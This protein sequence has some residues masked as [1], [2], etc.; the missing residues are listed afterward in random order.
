M[1]NRNSSHPSANSKQR[2]IV[3][4]KWLSLLPF[5][6]LQPL[7]LCLLRSSIIER[8]VGNRKF[9]LVVNTNYTNFTVWFPSP[10]APFLLWFN[11]RAFPNFLRWKEPGLQEDGCRVLLPPDTS[12]SP[13]PLYSTRKTEKLCMFTNKISHCCLFF[14][15]WLLFSF[16]DSSFSNSPLFLSPPL[17]LCFFFT[18]CILF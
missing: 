9:L 1:T 3:S 16:S 12:W 17:F 8:T 18:N 5:D 15:F 4:C 13:S 11:S 7:W 2:S 6:C 10:D 14:A